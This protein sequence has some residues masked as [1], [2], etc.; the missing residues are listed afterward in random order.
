M[1]LVHGYRYVMHPV[2]YM[3][4]NVTTVGSE[5][6]CTFTM[7]LSS[8]LGIGNYFIIST[9]WVVA[10]DIY[11]CPIEIVTCGLLWD[12]NNKSLLVGTYW[13]YS[14]ASCLALTIEQS[15]LNLPWVVTAS[16]YI[17][18]C[19]YALCQPQGRQDVIQLC[20]IRHP[21]CN[22]SSYDNSPTCRCAVTHFSDINLLSTLN[23]ENY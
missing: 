15:S 16:Q 11:Y 9:H 2:C 21:C 14:V 18:V 8:S 3:E 19:E 17:S 7:E 20:R 12:Y 1:P 13:G 22:I 4:K 23:K 5:S 6:H 10:I